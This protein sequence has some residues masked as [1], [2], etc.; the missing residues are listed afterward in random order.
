[1]AWPSYVAPG[2]IG[3]ALDASNRRR[4]H[5]ASGMFL[6]VPKAHSPRGVREMLGSIDDDEVL[7]FAA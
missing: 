3:P 5:V 1:M 2:G 4:C 7:A 6:V